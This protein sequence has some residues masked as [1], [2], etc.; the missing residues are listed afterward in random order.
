MEFVWK[1]DTVGIKLLLVIWQIDD[2]VIRAVRWMNVF[3]S[4]FYQWQLRWDHRRWGRQFYFSHA[5]LCWTLADS[6]RERWGGLRVVLGE[7]MAPHWGGGGKMAT[8]P[9][10]A[11]ILDDPISV[12]RGVTSWGHYRKWPHGK[13]KWGHPRW[14]EAELPPSCHLHLNGAPFV[15]PM[16]WMTSVGRLHRSLNV[17]QTSA[18][19]ETSR[20]DHGCFTENPNFSETFWNALWLCLIIILGSIWS[21]ASPSHSRNDWGSCP[22]ATTRK[23]IS[24]H[25]STPRLMGNC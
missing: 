12:F 19:H 16:S 11:A 13:R 8:V 24:L 1:F 2:F 3:Y 5:S 4:G 6:W 15:L 7:Q 23:S 10:P 9:L 22:L 25:M 21:L 20:A 18:S 14:P 17:L